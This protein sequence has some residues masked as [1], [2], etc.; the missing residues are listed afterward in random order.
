MLVTTLAKLGAGILVAGAASTVVAVPTILSTSSTSETIKYSSIS[1]YEKFCREFQQ[2]LTAIDSDGVSREGEGAKAKLIVCPVD[3]NSSQAVFYLYDLKE[4]PHKEVDELVYSIDSAGKVTFTL[5]NNNTQKTKET[6]RAY[7]ATWN[8]YSG[9]SLKQNCQVE[10]GN[11]EDGE[12][13]EITCKTSSK[14]SN[15]KAFL[16]VLNNSKK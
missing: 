6:Y 11:V 7:L 8:N 10:W 14:N 4:I 5:F 12:S 16:R 15:P 9:F 13:K 2:E 3:K 1:D